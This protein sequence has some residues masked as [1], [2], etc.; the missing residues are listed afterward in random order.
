MKPTTREQ[1][2][3]IIRK[4]LSIDYVNPDDIPNIDLYMDQVTTFMDSHLADSKR[5]DDDKIL[6]KT[7]INNYTKNNLLPPPVKKKYSKDHLF[8]LIFIYYLKNMFSISDIDH[9]IAPLVEMF[10][11]EKSDISLEDIYNT[12]VD[13]EN[14]HSKKV[15]QGILQCFK[16]SQDSFEHYD[17]KNKEEEDYLRHFSFICMLSYD[18]YMKKT[19]LD[20][21]IDNILTKEETAEEKAEKAAEKNT[22]QSNE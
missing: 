15:I 2:F 5:S 11:D 18:I 14:E 12:I 13:Q 20:R 4:M 8:L 6:T 22:S 16:D 17:F 9:I 1:I 10:Y 21:M 7:M 3:D 19:L